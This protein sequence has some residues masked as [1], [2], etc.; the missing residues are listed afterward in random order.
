MKELITLS[1]TA[2]LIH[3]T[4]EYS[5]RNYHPLPVVI[6]RGEGVWVWD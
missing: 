5:A 2:Q 1:R 3:E 4:E 6:A